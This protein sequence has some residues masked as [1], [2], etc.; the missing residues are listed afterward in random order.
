MDLSSGIKSLLAQIASWAVVAGLALVVFLNYD[1][2]KSATQATLGNSVADVAVLTP[3]QPRDVPSARSDGTVELKAGRNGH[4]QAR[5]DINGRGLPVMVDTGAS[6]VVLTYEDAQAA[7]VYVKASDFTQPVSTAN[8]TSRV[9]PVTLDRVSIGDITV[10]DVRA[11]VAG[12]GLLK[13]TLLGMS[14]LNKLQR[15]DMRD[16]MMVLKD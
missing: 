5:A 14:F 4:F 12:P 15:V 1:T 10:H 11:A 13:Q 3:A 8:G 2:L 9:A 16:G 6:I 7:G